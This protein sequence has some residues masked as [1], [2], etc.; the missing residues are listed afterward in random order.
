MVTW[1]FSNTVNYIELNKMSFSPPDKVVLG[2][3]QVAGV[4]SVEGYQRKVTS[5]REYQWVYF[6]MK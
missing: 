2:L 4:S 1:M 5:Y 3:W 6:P